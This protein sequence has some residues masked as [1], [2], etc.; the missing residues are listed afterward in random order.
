MVPNVVCMS[1]AHIQQA[2]ESLQMSYHQKEGTTT[3]GKLA[4][5]CPQEEN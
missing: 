3:K 5:V 1:L 4:Q 2:D